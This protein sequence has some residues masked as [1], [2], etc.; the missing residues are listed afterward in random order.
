MTEPG[1]T[2][3]VWPHGPVV[4]IWDELTPWGYQAMFG[5]SGVVT[6]GGGGC[7]RDPVGRGLRCCWT[8]CSAQDAP[9]RIIQAPV[10]TAPGLRSLV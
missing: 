3:D 8:S 4:L 9:Q 2:Q 7:Y 5:D 1:F 6:A 10:S